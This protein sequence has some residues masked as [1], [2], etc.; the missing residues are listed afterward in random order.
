MQQPWTVIA[1]ATL[2]A[3]GLG[4]AAHAACDNIPK[5]VQDAL[6]SEPGWELVRL[7]HFFEEEEE[8]WQEFHGRQ[9]P[10]YVAA[11]VDGSGR[12]TFALSLIKQ[13]GGRAEH[14][15]IALRPGAAGFVKVELPPAQPPSLAMFVVR[16]GPGKFTDFDTGR[17]IELATESFMLGAF[18]SATIL[19]Y[20]QDG[21]F[22]N[23][24][25]A[26]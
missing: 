9:C 12:Q 19:H 24:L 20:F 16:Q 6:T 1:A 17:K 13:A 15:L 8:F 5:P 10:G 11:D 26:R 18:A 2:L 25:V 22:Q 21:K 14:K 3:L 23:L 7:V 4:G